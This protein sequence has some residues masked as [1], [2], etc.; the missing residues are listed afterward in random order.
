MTSGVPY[1][2]DNKWLLKQFMGLQVSRQ[3]SLISEWAHKK[4]RLSSAV[5]TKPG[6]WSNKYAP[7]TVEIMDCFAPDNPVK[8]VAV[9]KGGQVTLTTGVLENV[10][11]WVIDE[12]PAPIMYLTGS[13]EMAKVGIE[14]KVD[15]MLES[16][17]LMEKIRAPGKGSRKSGNTT[18][19]KD[20]RGGF[21]LTS[22]ASS[23]KR[24]KSVSVQYLL[25]DEIEEIAEFLGTQG[26]PV[27]MARVRQRSFE[28]KRKTLYL[29]TP[30]LE[31][32]P[33]HR[34][35]LLGDQRYYYVPCKH[36]GKNQRLVFRGKREDDK[37]YGISYEVDRDFVLIY[38]SVQYICKYCLGSWK[39]YDKY[40][41]LNAGFWK[42]TAKAKRNQFRSYQIGSEYSPDG[43]YSWESMVEEWLECW[44]ERTRKIINVE[45]LKVFVNQSRG[46]PYE[47]RGESPKYETVIRHRRSIYLRNQ[48]PNKAAIVE[49]GSPV[50]MLTCA[51]DVHKR[52]LM[53]E[54]KGWCVGSRS[55]SIDWRVLEGDTDDLQG[56]AW[57]ALREI[58]ENESWKADDGKIYQ[59][60]MTLIDAS[61]RTDE[62]YKFASDYSECVFAIMGREMPT[63]NAKMSQFN[64]YENKKE[65]ITA[66]NI[67]VTR[68]KD[69]IAGWLRRDW[70]DG[71][72]QPIGYP[73][74]PENYGDDF[75]KQYEAE[76]KKKKRYKTGSLGSSYVWMQKPNEA[77]HAWDAAVY[78]AAALDIKC[79]DFTENHLKENGINYAAFFKYIEENKTFYHDGS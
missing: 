44:C 38:E 56:K 77:N 63:K 18:T 76:E 29:S 36:C 35:F 10:I 67:T 73:N 41:F 62:V 79:Y 64:S 40:D 2:G 7:F 14:I 78:G 70:N 21:L 34:L 28:G 32:G 59:V 15:R 22:G 6:Q 50:L 43:G 1:S 72:L 3:R 26:D 47:E 4:R 30:N 57:S 66:Y 17:G 46:L 19:R 58:I 27:K 52:N 39:N 48:I 13:E 11:G 51:V 53:V 37:H 60:N 55:Y 9:M 74:Y 23:T 71:E 49:T 33:I 16:A 20:F 5:T 45:A 69:R 42:P 54:I 61:Y 25:I 68:Y 8:E 12:N 75:F 24:L 31:G 65:G